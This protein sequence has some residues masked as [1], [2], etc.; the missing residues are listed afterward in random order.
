MAVGN[1]V[2]F[3]YYTS[4]F[5]AT[6]DS[7]TIYFLEEQKEIRVGSRV[8]ANVDDNVVTPAALREVLEAYTIKNVEFV[9]TGNNISDISLN[10]TTGRLTVTKSNLPVLAKGAA[11]SPTAVT[12]QPSGKFRSLTTVSVDGH[13]I[14]DSVTEYELPAQITNLRIFVTDNNKLSFELVKSDGTSSTVEFGGLGSAAFANRTEFATA[15]QGTK[16][17]NAMSKTGGEASDAKITLRSD[18]VGELEA[19]TKRYVDRAVESAASNTR[20]LGNSS[21]EITDAGTQAPTINGSVIPT[22]N[23]R[24]G[25]WV[26]Y[27]GTQYI[28]SGSQWNAYGGNTHSVPDTRLVTA[29]TGLTGGGQLNADITISHAEKHEANTTDNGSEDLKVVDGVSFD[30]MGHISA[31]HKKDLNSQI[32][33]KISSAVTPVNNQVSELANNLNNN[34]YTKTQTDTA[35]DAA[36]GEMPEVASDGEFNEM[37]GEVFS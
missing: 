17:D 23:L 4:G 5:P 31:V 34:Y 7:D 26:T 9:G 1:D 10:Q 21:T 37:M 28:W 3:A 6:Y 18:P 8:L 36:V 22:A 32:N 12:L 2:K 13:T 29:G 16:A 19:A 15:A 35:I 14:T 27:E 24:I 30:K 25:D 33:T 11:P 20:Y